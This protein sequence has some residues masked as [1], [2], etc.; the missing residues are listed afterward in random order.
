MLIW[1]YLGE[2]LETNRG[3]SA[4]L[5]LIFEQLEETA[6]PREY[7]VPLWHY[8]L[9]CWTASFLS[10]WCGA[11]GGNQERVRRHTTTIWVWIAGKHDALG[12]LSVQNSELVYLSSIPI[13]IVSRPLFFACLFLSKLHPWALHESPSTSTRICTIMCFDK[14]VLRYFNE[15]FWRWLKG[16]EFTAYIRNEIQSVDVLACQSRIEKT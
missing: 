15:N 14:K 10:S 11:W 4:V 1:W 2:A 7:Q 3:W 16:P 9:A 12:I 8:W 5:V 6:S 13:L